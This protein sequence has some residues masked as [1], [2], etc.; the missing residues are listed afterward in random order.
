MARS[1]FRKA[2][3]FE[4]RTTPPKD[5]RLFGAKCDSCPLK[6]STPVWGDG[7]YR[8]SL[9]LIG[10][11]PGREEVSAGMPFIGKSGQY[12]EAL[13]AAKNLTR[14]DVWLDNAIL[15]FPDGG[16]LKVFLQVARK[17]HKVSA[18]DE[19]FMSPIDCCRP[20]LFRV[21]G[22]PQCRKCGKWLKVPE[23]KLRCTCKHPTVVKV[24]EPGAKAR[25]MEPPAA[26]LA[27]GNSALESLT[28]DGGIKAK[29]LYWFTGS[30]K[31][32]ENDE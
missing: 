21:L 7:T 16:D 22:I 23:G 24:S 14:S 8:R 20:R 10:E 26:A 17:K 30:G 4:R 2:K 27:F 29:Q 3:D 31:S 32:A 18:Y 6:G 12:V 19:P 1:Y 9:A 25:T 11:A 5:P 15:C 28:G 13:L